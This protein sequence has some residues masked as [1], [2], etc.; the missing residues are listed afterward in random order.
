ME[1][2]RHHHGARSLGLEFWQLEASARPAAGVPAAAEGGPSSAGATGFMAAGQAEGLLQD[3]DH[4][5]HNLSRE[6]SVSSGGDT[7]RQAD[8]RDREPEQPSPA[9]QDPAGAR[10][11]RRGRP[12][13][14]RIPF[15][16]TQG[17][18]QELESVF[19]ETQ[20]PD[21]LTR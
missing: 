1:N 16:F 10:A 17:Q 12:P 14:R 8:D 13:R 4:D 9:E 5:G 19:Q 11:G 21:V 3:D 20:Y 18:V 7:A 6:V 2:Q 15:S